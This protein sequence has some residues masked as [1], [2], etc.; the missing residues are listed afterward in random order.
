MR[1]SSGGTMRFPSTGSG[2]TGMRLIL[3]LRPERRRESWSASRSESLKSR[4]R[5]YS[6]VSFRPFSRG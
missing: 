1:S 6:K 4:M 2:L 3:A 5:M